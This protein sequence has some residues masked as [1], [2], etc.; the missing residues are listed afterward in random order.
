[1]GQSLLTF[2]Q[3]S[4]PRLV[5]ICSKQIIPPVKFDHLVFAVLHF[6][7][8]HLNDARNCAK[9]MMQNYS[10]TRL[11]YVCALA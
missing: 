9:A 7:Q 3:G 10:S 6:V 11:R 4:C 5:D 1:M 2:K 8:V